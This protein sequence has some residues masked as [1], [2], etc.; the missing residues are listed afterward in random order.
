MTEVPAPPTAPPAPPGAL[1]PLKLSM[2]P[3]IKPANEDVVRNLKKM[4]KNICSVTS[5][6][7]I[8]KNAILDI[9]R[10]HSQND[11]E[12]STFHLGVI[13]PVEPLIQEG[14]QCG[15]VALVMASQV[16]NHPASIDTL[17]SKA[18]ELNYTEQGEMFSADD[19]VSLASLTLK[20][21]GY[22]IASED[23]KT[24]TQA[25]LNALIKNHVVL[26]PYDRDCNNEPCLKEGR[27]AHW[28]IITGFLAVI[29][30]SSDRLP[31]CVTVNA[32][33]P[34]LLHPKFP[35]DAEAVTRY[36]MKSEDLR[37]FANQGKSIRTH[38]WS[39]KSLLESN[40]Q[41]IQLGQEIK[42]ARDAYV[43]KDIGFIRNKV[44]ILYPKDEKS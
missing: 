18:K 25:I 36:A 28:A 23:L 15:L 42:I 37:V 44:V 32:T 39:M 30:S 29:S 6:V 13:N 22:V 11:F 19:L 1:L 10:F 38:L 14:P 17:F 26:I 33:N 2:K 41:L 31:S 16:L 34:S 24:K 12:N 7:D 9:K 21:N 35:V 20:C 3:A 4:Q 27:K 40:S 8:M 5:P 43:V